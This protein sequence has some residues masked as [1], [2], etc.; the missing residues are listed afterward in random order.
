MRAMT[1]LCRRLCVGFLIRPKTRLLKSPAYKHL[2]SNTF[3][4]LNTAYSLT[5]CVTTIP[6]T[7]SNY[8]PNRQ[9]LTRQSDFNCLSY[10]PITKK[11]NSSL[12]CWNVTVHKCYDLNNFWPVDWKSLVI[13]GRKSVF[14]LFWQLM[15]H[16]G[17]KKY[18]I[19]KLFL[20]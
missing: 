12:T 17:Q 18:K 10:P 8:C 1:S 9:L 7:M 5:N 11:N 6:T 15:L 13:R 20:I 14:G 16:E 4:S 3:Q 19:K 2:N